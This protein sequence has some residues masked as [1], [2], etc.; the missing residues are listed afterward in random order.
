MTEGQLRMMFG[1]SIPLDAFRVHD[2][3]N[4]VVRK[5]LIENICYNNAVDYFSIEL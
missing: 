5:G 2:W 4:G 1:D 3:R